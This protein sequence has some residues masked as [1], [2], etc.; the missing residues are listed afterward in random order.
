MEGSKD[1]SCLP[2]LVH[3]FLPVSHTRFLHPLAGVDFI[4]GRL[5]PQIGLQVRDE[6]V[7]EEGEREEG[8]EREREG[9][10]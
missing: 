1:G 10:S 9:E 5:D 6:S 2:L 4:H 3:L 7:L 8:R